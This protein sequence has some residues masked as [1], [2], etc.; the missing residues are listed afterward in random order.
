MKCTLLFTVLLI[1]CTQIFAQKISGRVLDA[2]DNTPLQKA[3]V[4]S[5]TNVRTVTDSLGYFELA[6]SLGDIFSL[7][8]S[9]IGFYTDTTFTNRKTFVEVKLKPL[10][11]D[12][13]EVV[14]R[15]VTR[16]ELTPMNVEVITSADLVKDACCNLSESFE[17]SATVDV[18][19]SDAVSGAK[20]IR[21]LGLDGVYTQTMIENVP[22][23][24]GL[25]S[26]FGMN[27]IPGPLMS[28]IQVNKGIGSVVNGYEPIAG[29]INIELKKPLNAE[30]VLVNYFMNQD[31]RS[32][33]NLLTARSIN[34]HWSTLTFVHGDVNWWKQDMNHDHYIDN[35]LIKNGQ[36]LQR[37]S[38]MSG[39][40]FSFIAVLN[41]NVEDRS[42]GSVHFK[43]NKPFEAQND[44]GL[45]LRTYHADA[46][47]KTAFNL[48][49]ENYIGI[50][51][52]YQYH[53]QFG[54][55]GRKAYSGN[56]HFGYFNFIYQKNWGDEEHAV[57]V[58]ASM[59]VDV[60]TEQLDSILLHRKEYVPGVFAEGSFNF[61]TD[62]KVMLLAGFRT[63][64]HN[65][66]GPF[67][68]P[69]VNLKWRITYDLS[70]R[71]GGGKG[72]RVPSL[73]AEN[74]GWLAN[75]RQVS[76]TR[77]NLYESAWNVGAGLVYKFNAWFRTGTISIDYYRTDFERQVVIDLEDVR[78]IQ[79]YALDGRSFANALQVEADYEVLKG[80]DVK[81]AYKFEQTKTD[82]KSG[83][84]I[85]PLK[86]QHRG[87]VSLQYQTPG[88]HWRFNTGV[89]WFGKTRIPDTSPNLPENQRPLI[90]K[91][92]FQLNAQITF[93]IKTWEVY[94]GG[95]NLLNFIQKQPII[96]GDA[97]LSNQF[98]ASLVWGPLRGAMAFAGF[99]WY[100]K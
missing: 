72:Y 38:Y 100:M 70:F 97:P 37:F 85:F 18:S 96:S 3:F 11:M 46:M 8:T 19:F 57:K 65:L 28:S 2:S 47:F 89:N 64:F 77:H 94:V 5:N 60:V 50:Q 32:E 9:Y 42:G 55:I 52:K 7:R 80:F 87:L 22:A 79:M 54:N 6:D 12:D 58:G 29:Q 76:I 61:G 71:I 34:Q 43:P 69:R 25:Y 93:S 41:G 40:V 91:D 73:L 59:Q 13:V 99:R 67:V 30:K 26:T 56:E 23:V 15:A 84:K 20:E 10:V 44:W 24:R 4:Q 31:L 14:S 63:D 98:D 62:N 81:L 53:N 17:N 51:Y 39:K 82:Y 75:N 95:E 74:F 49:N 16:K 86:P 90:S 21:M 33:L 66:Y 92:W 36:V 1:F 35:P 68:S 88:K 83:R 48:P 27:Y 45:K 78:Q